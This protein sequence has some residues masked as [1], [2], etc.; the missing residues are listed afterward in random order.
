MSDG[1]EKKELLKFGDCMSFC[2]G[3]I[4][5]SGIMVLTGI[6]LARTGRG[7]PL[8][9]VVAAAIIMITMVPLAVLGA[10]MP[11]TGGNYVYVRELIGRKSGLVYVVMFAVSQCLISTFALGFADYLIAVV[12]GVN[13]TLA[14]MALLIVCTGFN[15]V[16]VKTA[17]KLQ[18]A[19]VVVL[20]VALGAYIV[21]GLPKVNF[22]GFFE[23]G[24]IMP[25][26]FLNFL[27]ASALL[28][29]PMG[30][31]KFIAE[32]GGDIENPGKN[33]PRS[34]FLSTGIV[35]IF[36]ALMGV[37]AAGVLPIDQVAGK[38]LVVSAQEIFPRPIYLFFVIGGALFALATT[39]NG[40]LSWITKGLYVAAK[41]GWIPESM[42]DENK[43]GVPYKLLIVF[44]IIGA[45]PILTGMDVSFISSLGVG[46]TV[47]CNVLPVGSAFFFAEKKPEAYKNA[48]FK[49]SV[50]A[51]K[52]F[53][54]VSIILLLATGWLNLRDLTMPTW[55]SLVVFA[56]LCVL[57]ANVREK[58][59]IEKA[60]ANGGK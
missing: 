49:V 38:T 51:L 29:F 28:Y 23:P 6:A 37:V 44:F 46:L 11:G 14:A 4:I 26:G 39:L 59:V 1:A 30:G 10:G 8:G 40:T 32:L 56:I 45:V 48:T 36:Y 43:Y 7:V 33:I 16:G 3:Q 22:A 53:S 42:A 17:A 35:A 24:A 60:Q 25:N 21:F 9:F 2:I 5:G 31:A 52:A 55:I 57:Y 58:K 34:M 18:T 15:M 41:E 54:V 19:M 20:L 50:P 13:R 47:I 12:P 27:Q